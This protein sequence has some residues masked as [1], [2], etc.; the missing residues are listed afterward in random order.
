MTQISHNESEAL[1]AVCS[2]IA[3]SYTT[4]A[5]AVCLPACDTVP[6]CAGT[7]C[8]VLPAALG[9]LQPGPGAGAWT[10]ASD[11][12]AT[13]S[14]PLLPPNL[15]YTAQ[16]GGEVGGK[17]GKAGGRGGVV[18]QRVGVSGGKRHLWSADVLSSGLKPFSY[19][20]SWTDCTQGQKSVTTLLS[21]AVL[22]PFRHFTP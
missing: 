8:R 10:R 21:C 5:Q 9:A 22:R 14:L 4:L 7:H 1:P 3:P 6:A 2:F 11:Q 12:G 15:E 16:R 20:C 19:S 17:K 18:N 13:S